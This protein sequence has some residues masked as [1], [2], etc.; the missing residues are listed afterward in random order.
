MADLKA[1]GLVRRIGASLCLYR[2]EIDSLLDRY[3][4]DLIQAPVNALDTRACW[5]A[6]SIDRMEAR[7][8]AVHARSH[9]SAGSAVA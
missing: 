6:A 2:A 4:P 7:G 3:E 1:A 8:V 9:V 5:L